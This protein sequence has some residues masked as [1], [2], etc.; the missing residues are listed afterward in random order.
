MR[1]TGPETPEN[2]RP[3]ELANRRK[4]NREDALETKSARRTP[5]ESVRVSKE[6]H[7]LAETRQDVPV[8]DDA[9][10]ERLKQA[11]QNGTFQV[12]ANAI[13]SRMLKEERG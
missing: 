2:R 1:I 12:D 8:H 9:K 4:A 5:T 13:A 11:L 3:E 10:V 6:A 7:Q